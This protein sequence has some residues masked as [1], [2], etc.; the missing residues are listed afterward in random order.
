MRKIFIDAGAHEGCS[1]R[2]F[3]REIDKKLEY[4]VY[5][6]E[7][8]PYFLNRF[9][10][11]K[12]HTFINK[13]VWVRDGKKEFYVSR[14]RLKAGGTLMPKKKSGRLDKKNPITVK[15]IDFS[16]W[17]ARTL[18]KDDYIILKMDIEGAEY[19]VLSKMI[20]DGVFSY[21]NELL[22]EWHYAKIKLPISEHNKL[23]EQIHIPIKK[24][25]ALKACKLRRE[26]NG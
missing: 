25:C 24:W 8:D 3:R 13:A 16:Q 4:Y 12:N 9:K 17:V 15:T 6:F 23:V 11:M 22:I 5:S 10:D 18:S 2:K 1:V 7:I 20:K 14:E 21:I 19:Q 26:N